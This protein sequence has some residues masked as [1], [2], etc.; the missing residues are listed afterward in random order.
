MPRLRHFIFCRRA[1]KARQ[2]A[3]GSLPIFVTRE[4]LDRRLQ[5]VLLRGRQDA[6]GCPPGHPHPHP[7]LACHR[8]CSVC[9][10]QGSSDPLWFFSTSTQKSNRA[11]F[12]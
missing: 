6:R 5:L 3:G 7:L 4:T 2:E 12:I 8:E 1:T 11:Y 10:D 9:A